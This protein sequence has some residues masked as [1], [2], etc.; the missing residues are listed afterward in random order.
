MGS[1]QFVADMQQEIDLAQRLDEFPA[2]Q[3][4][5]P[6]LPLEHYALAAADRD[7]AI[8]QAYDTGGCTLQTIG[9]HFGLNYSRVSRIVSRAKSKT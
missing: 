7:E 6:P 3:H 8:L 2:S 1:E 4:R 5:A 9:N